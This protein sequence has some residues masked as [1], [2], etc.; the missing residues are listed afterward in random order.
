MCVTTRGD[1]PQSGHADQM[2][3]RVCL[4]GWVCAEYLHSITF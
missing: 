1:A 2:C 4:G 3:V